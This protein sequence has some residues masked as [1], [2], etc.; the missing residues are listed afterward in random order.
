MNFKITVQGEVVRP[1]VHTVNS[2]RLTLPEAIAL[3]IF[4]PSNI[5]NKEEITN[6]NK[7]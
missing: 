2:E 4:T 3:S 1:G 5:I 6:I 7:Y